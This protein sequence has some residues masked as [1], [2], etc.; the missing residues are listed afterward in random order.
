MGESRG[1]G[2]PPDGL[3]RTPQRAGRPKRFT[4]KELRI[5]R[6]TRLE[7][8]AGHRLVSAYRVRQR[9]SFMP[10]AL[11]AA[12]RSFPGLVRPATLPDER[13]KKAQT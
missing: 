13:P 6:P 5:C 9:K 1:D 2:R 4:E 7:C 10:K 3:V 12:G 11:D 8:V